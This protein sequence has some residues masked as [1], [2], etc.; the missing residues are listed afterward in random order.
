MPPAEVLAANARTIRDEALTE[1]VTEELAGMVDIDALVRQLIADHPDLAGVD[2]TRAR[3]MFTSRDPRSWW[4]VTS[5]LVRGDISAV[6][7]LAD[8]ARAHLV[9]QLAASTDDDEAGETP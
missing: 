1:L 7:R 2:E 6:D 8:T 3:D 4:A 5:Q 9:E